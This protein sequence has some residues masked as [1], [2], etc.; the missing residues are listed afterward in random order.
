MFSLHSA[1]AAL[2]VNGVLASVAPAQHLSLVRIAEDTTVVVPNG[3]YP[4]VDAGQVALTGID[5]VRG[6][7]TI[8]IGPSNGQ[9][10]LVSL[11]SVGDASPHTSGKLIAWL[12]NPA[13]VAGAAYF[14]AGD[15]F[16]GHGWSGYDGIYTAS[17]TTSV[18]YVG[19]GG[20][21][22][23]AGAS[24]VAFLR[25]TY[26]NVMPL[27]GGSETLLLVRGQSLPGG[28]TYIHSDFIEMPA[29]DGNFVSVPARTNVTGGTSYG[30]YTIDITSGTVELVAN[31]SSVVP[32]TSEKFTYLG[33]TDHDAN[34]VAFFGWS[35]TKAGIFSAPLHA[36]GAGP[37]TAWVMD[38]DPAPGGGTFDTVNGVFG[39]SDG[40]LAFTAWSGTT[41]GLY[42]LLDGTIHTVATSA[43]TL[44]GRTVSHFTFSHRGFDGHQLAFRATFTDGAKGYGVFV[45]TLD[46][47]RNGG[48]PGSG[49]FVPTLTLD[50]LPMPGED[51]TLSLR[52]GLGGSLALLVFGT[53]FADLPMGKSG[54][55]L[56]VAPLLPDVLSLFLTGSGAG[57]GAFDLA[58]TIPPSL[59]GVQLVTQ[60][61]VVDPGVP[62]G[63]TVSNAVMVLDA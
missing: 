15:E 31:G 41:E 27:N 51:I 5:T 12:W 40:A 10:P 7:D 34:D 24:G 52:D 63:F 17:T 19:L 58:E 55:S 26:P 9:G 21:P 16:P 59:I 3:Q 46:R 37:I 2:V 54:G 61:L 44:G 56:H 42:L 8:V 45:A 22:L 49:G 11:V 20:L 43:T 1:C 6:V 60:T 48:C 47:T 28:G 13:L 57:T 36:N 32:G 53:D 38:G 14:P 35:K 50:G 23:S 33:A 30:C 62:A 18:Q 29:L 25:G 4:V 39:W